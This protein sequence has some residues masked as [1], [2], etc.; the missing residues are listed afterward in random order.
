MKTVVLL[1][2]LVLVGGC[3]LFSPFYDEGKSTDLDDMIGDVQA[4]LERGEPDKAYDYAVR[5]IEK[6]PTSVTLHY[7][8]AV[9]RVGTEDVHFSDF[10]TMLRGRQ[11]DDMG[12]ASAILPL[13][14]A[15]AAGDTTLFLDISPDELA[16]LAAAYDVSYD[17]LQTAANLI[18]TGGVSE[19][20]LIDYGGD[21]NL[22]LG[23]SGLLKTM[24]TVLDT[25]HNLANGFVLNPSIQPYRVD[26][27]EGGESWGFT[28]TLDPSIVCEALPSMIVAQEALYDHFRSVV[29]GDWPADI[30]SDQVFA[31]M[32]WAPP[33]PD[34]EKLLDALVGK[35]LFH[36]HNGLVSFHDKYSCEGEVSHE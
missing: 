5:G 27:P 12:Y 24:L 11:E 16:R 14:P 17:L 31:P 8:G 9:A 1:L 7:L 3:N 30:P 22:G 13:G 20:E 18:G 25:D 15:P 33:L 35:F 34:E 29:A 36:L 23:I 21:I 19:Q 32:P 2:A 26:T 28:A 6:H 4:A 10:S